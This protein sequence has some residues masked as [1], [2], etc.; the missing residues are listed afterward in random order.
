MNT[1]RSRE[2]WLKQVQDFKK[3]GLSINGYCRKNHLAPSTFIYWI[4]KFD[5]SKNDK[6]PKLVK[7]SAPMKQAGT[8]TLHFNDVSI[9]FPS[10]LAIDKISKLIAVLKEV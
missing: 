2:E 8:M 9:E 10:E 5:N 1:K 4:K 3:S 7:L 6:I